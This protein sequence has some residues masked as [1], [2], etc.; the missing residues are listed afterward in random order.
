[1]EQDKLMA[2]KGKWFVLHHNSVMSTLKCRKKCDIV[3]S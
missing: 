2:Y 3:S 1:M